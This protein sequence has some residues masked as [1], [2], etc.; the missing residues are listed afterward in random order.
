MEQFWQVHVLVL[1]PPACSTLVSMVFDQGERSEFLEV[2]VEVV[3]VHAQLFL[4]L[5]RAHLIGLCQ[6][7]IGCTA[8][9]VGESGCDGVASHSSHSRTCSDDGFI[10]FED[11]V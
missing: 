7:D 3:A 4:E 11:V 9:G 6:C 5:N 8:C 10:G 2:M 1:S